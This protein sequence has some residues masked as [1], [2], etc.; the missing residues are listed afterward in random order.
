MFIKVLRR[1]FMKI[2]ILT[3]K[4]VGKNFVFDPLST[5]VLPKRLTV[6]NNVFIGPKAYI[7]ADIEF[8]D[9]VMVGPNLTVIGGDH[10]FGVKGKYNRFIKSEDL[11]ED[12]IKIGKDVWIGA[13]VTILK[14]VE[15]GD[16]TIIGA[17]SLVTKSIP[18]FKVAFGN[19]CKPIRN[20]FI[21]NNEL[22]EHLNLLGYNEEEISKILKKREPLNAK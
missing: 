15:I 5:I 1:L 18:P 11:L 13:N 12:K 17:G 9:N 20:V 16:G 3:F 4:S 10:R 2:R 6:G 19:P 7:S 22:L 21:S 8:L 14:G